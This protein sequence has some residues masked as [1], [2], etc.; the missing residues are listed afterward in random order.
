MAAKPIL[1]RLRDYDRLV[2]IFHIVRRY[3]ALNAF[4]G[5]VTIVGL[6]GGFSVAGVSDPRAVV[7]AGLSTAMAMGISGFWGAYFT[8]AAER[9]HALRELSRHTL[10]DLSCS[11]WGRAARA[12]VV[13]VTLVDGLSPMLAAILVLTPFFFASA[14]GDVRIVYAASLSIAVVTLFLLGV[15][16]G[17]LSR[18][19][20]MAFGAKTA[21][22]G[23]VATVVAVLFGV[24]R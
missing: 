3:L 21:L 23:I 22:A 10:T 15:F 12:A 7:V 18:R 8:E 20:M 6:I 2:G 5:V 24:I 1:T 14:F 9:A 11:Q 16:L 19:S 4:D 17:K 13:L